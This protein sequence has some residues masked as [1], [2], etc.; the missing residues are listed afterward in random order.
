MIGRPS[1]SRRI[2]RGHPARA[3]GFV[4]CVAACSGPPAVERGGPPPWVYEQGVGYVHL[5]T[6]KT[7]GAA[8][9]LERGRALARDGEVEEALE[10]FRA[11]Y[12]GGAE[13]SRKSEALLEEARVLAGAGRRAEAQQAYI[14]FLDRYAASPLVPEVLREAFDNA[15]AFAEEGD[16]HRIGGI[17]LY[18]TDA[19]GLQAVRDLLA[20]FPREDFSGSCAFRLAEYYFDRG[21]Y[22]VASAEFET[23]RREYARTPWAE[24]ALFRVGL[25]SLRMSKGTPYNPRP[26]MD[27]RQ[28]FEKFLEEYPTSRL[29]GDDGKGGKGARSLLAEVRSLQAQKDYEVAGYYSDRDRQV[30]ARAMYAA[31]VK[32]YPDTTAG[33]LARRELEKL[34]PAPA[35]PETKP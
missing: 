6:G 18:S 33:E 1:P 31:V 2:G 23:V 32:D 35:P 14:E 4:L 12:Q 8:E 3:L 17:R 24:A 9:L 29:V 25:C 26:L 7:L 20:R 34:P 11:L 27:A 16:P 22:E 5:D 30:A 10:A 19:P 15:F 13:A 28:R 21:E